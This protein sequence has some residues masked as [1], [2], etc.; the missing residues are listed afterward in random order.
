MSCFHPLIAFDFGLKENGKKDLVFASGRDVTVWQL[1]DGRVSNKRVELPCGQCIGCRLQYSRM[2]AD[3]CMMELNYHDSAYFLTLTY[4]DEYLNDGR[5]D[6]CTRRYYP[7]PETGEAKLSLSLYK[8]D[9]QK[10]WKRLRKAFPD[11]HIRYYA[12]GEYGDRTKRPHYHAI[13][14]GL[15]LDDLQFY[16]SSGLKDVYYNSPSLSKLWPYGYVVVGHVSWQSCAYV[17][18]Y[19]VKKVKG[20]GKDFYDAFNLTP[21]FVV[22]SRKPGIGS[23]YFDDCAADFFNFGETYISTDKGGLRCKTPRYFKKKMELI[24]AVKFNDIRELNIKAGKMSTEAKIQ[25][26]DLTLEELRAVEEAAVLERSKAL[27]REL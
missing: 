10:F 1:P 26:T 15:H 11:D 24:D 17:A 9:L 3:R 18:R 13:V 7:D 14:Y 23:A 21:E 5:Q 25:L 19:V 6:G 8:P 20:A 27:K 2:W 4:S 22:M 12:C 16:K